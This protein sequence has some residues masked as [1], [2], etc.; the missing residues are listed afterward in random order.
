MD[1][2]NAQPTDVQSHRNSHVASDPPED[3]PSKR[4]IWLLRLKLAVAVTMPVFLETLDY[5]GASH[6]LST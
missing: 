4:Q 2:S 3:V 5:T 6:G 1:D